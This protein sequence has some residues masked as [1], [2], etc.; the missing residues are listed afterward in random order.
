MITAAKDSHLA[1]DPIRRNRNDIWRKKTFI[2][3]YHSYITYS[4]SAASIRHRTSRFQVGEAIETPRKCSATVHDIL[5][6]RRKLCVNDVFSCM[7]TY[8]SVYI[9][10]KCIYSVRRLNFA[11]IGR[12]SG[13]ILENGANARKDLL[14]SHGARRPPKCST[15]V[16][17]YTN[18]K[19]HKNSS[20]WV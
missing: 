1:R 15:T 11:R 5:W 13:N 4:P 12:G 10:A 20:W 16:M 3:L 2:G 7:Y 9:I 8:F 17:N 6:M 18:T 19:T 14:P